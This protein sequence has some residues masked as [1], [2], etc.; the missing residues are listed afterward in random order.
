MSITLQKAHAYHVSIGLNVSAY[1][2][3]PFWWSREPL[4]GCS[5]GASAVNMSAS[6]WHFPDGL[7]A[8]G[9]PMMLFVQ[10]FAAN[11]VT[12]RFT[13]AAFL[14][15]RVTPLSPLYGTAVMCFLA[16]SLTPAVPQTFSSRSLTLTHSLPPSITP[17]LPHS[18]TTSL[19]HSHAP[20]MTRLSCAWW[21]AATWALS[22]AEI[23]ATSK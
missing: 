1:H 8:L 21:G 15:I 11:N 17:S 6:P 22:S 12:P 10:S 13:A 23:A 9:V 2:V 18:L 19:P 4:G 16:P 5:E 3:D 7:A 14:P 20:C